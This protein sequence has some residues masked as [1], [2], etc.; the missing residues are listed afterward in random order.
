METKELL[1][2]IARLVRRNLELAE[3]S[4]KF[5]QSSR[6]WFSQYCR[7]GEA[8]EEEKELSV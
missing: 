1:E 7:R 3:E 2:L 6:Y 4:K 8:Q 5:A